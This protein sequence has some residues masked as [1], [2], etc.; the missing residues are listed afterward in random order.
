MAS[1]IA[2]V[3]IY[4]LSIPLRHTFRHAA[5]VRREAD[6]VVVQIELASGVVGYGETLPRSY[7]TG[8]S[9]ES[10]A[11]AIREDL[12]NDLLAF[13]PRNF[14][15]ALEHIDTLPTHNDHGE[16][17][18]AARAGV[19][20]AL[21]DAYSRYFHKTMNEVVGWFGIPGLGTPGSLNKIRYSAVLSGGNI[22]KLAYSTRLMRWFGMRD[23]KLK[24]GYD[25]DVGRVHKVAR[26]LGGSLGKT[27]TLRLDAN[28]AWTFP[29]AVETLK[30]IRHIPIECVE[31]PLP[32]ERDDDLPALKRAVAVR[33]MADESLI[34]LADARR[35][36]ELQV[37]DAL[38]IRISKNGGFLA[39]LRMAH[40]ARKQNLMFQLG[41]M[42]GETSILSAAGRRFLEQVPGVRFAEGSYGRLLLRGDV[43]RRSVR[44]GYGGKAGTL[45]KP[46]WGI[47]VEQSLLVRHARL[48]VIEF[49]L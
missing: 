35:L 36:S 2:C 37:M 42:V 26:A 29:Q 32:R 20:L 1:Q 18:I 40:F 19:E 31:Q 11:R 39:A 9:P 33:I 24:V 8:E 38:N 45:P 22:R 34:T 10:V 7:V 15:E 21:I 30:A 43:V 47:Q 27:T 23:F 25:D 14:A 4:P 17:I 6:P 12:L 5:H 41:C 44:F 13:H 3:R 48:G 49:P 16:L 28:G 46:G